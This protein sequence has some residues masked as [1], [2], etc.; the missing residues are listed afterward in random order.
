[1]VLPFRLLLVLKVR[2]RL[3]GCATSVFV[4]VCGLFGVWCGGVARQNGPPPLLPPE[5]PTATRLRGAPSFS[6]PSPEGGCF[7][8]DS[9]HPG[10]KEGCS[11]ENVLERER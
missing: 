4:S 11:G 1:M 8:S 5:S 10:M 7:P 6:S 9:R 2:G 3:W